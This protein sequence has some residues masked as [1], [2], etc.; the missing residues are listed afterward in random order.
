MT[1]RSSILDTSGGKRES[2]HFQSL[3]IFTSYAEPGLNEFLTRKEQIE[4]ENKQKD[5]EDRLYRSVGTQP[6]LCIGRRTYVDQSCSQLKGKPKC[7]S[8]L[9]LILSS[10]KLLKKKTFC[11]IARSN[12][13][14]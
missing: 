9:L 1:S 11:A 10:H 4:L 5:E 14:Y 7:D 12:L 2:K 6:T 3:Q 8:F 13:F